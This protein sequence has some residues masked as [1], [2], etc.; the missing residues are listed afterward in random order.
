M[1]IYFKNL[2]RSRSIVL[3]RYV[4]DL[5]CQKKMLECDL[6]QLEEKKKEIYRKIEVIDIKLNEYVKE[7]E[8]LANELSKE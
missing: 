4:D 7:Q 6:D 5:K 2:L 1:S 8:G 3:V